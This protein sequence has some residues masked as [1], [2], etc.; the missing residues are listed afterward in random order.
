MQVSRPV[1]R[2]A[3]RALSLM[4]VVDIRQGAGTYITSLEP[5]QLVSHLDFVFSKDS[6]ALVQVL[7]ARRVIETGNVRLA[8]VRVTDGE[9]AALEAILADLRGAHRR[10][11]PVQRASTS[12]STTTI[13]AA[14]GNF[15]LLQ[16]MNIISTLGQVSR[17]RTGGLRAVREARAP[18]P[19]RDRR[20]APG[21]RPGRRRG[22]D[23]R[24]PRPRRGG[25]HDRARPTDAARHRR[26]AG[27]HP[28]SRTLTRRAPRVRRDLRPRARSSASSP[29]A[30]D[31]A[32]RRRRVPRAGSRCGCPGMVGTYRTVVRLVDADPP[33]RS[34]SRARSSARSARSRGRANF[35]LPRPDG[36]TA[37]DYEGQ[38]RIGGP[39]A[40]LDSRFAE[41]LAGSLINQGLGPRRPDSASPRSQTAGPDGLRPTTEGPEVTVTSYFLPGSLPEALGLLERHGPDCW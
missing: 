12:R 11:G 36:R 15:L 30:R 4:K 20:G 24:A 7:E 16:F 3:L 23:A 32:G 19:R 10:C 38:R 18:G 34:G 6:V 21:T 25:P 8:A 35:R 41:G 1:L 2:E 9:L 31:R 5:Q 26:R 27:D 13:C 22:G 28:G 33:H 40:R 17:E 14:A 37:I 39:L 29:A